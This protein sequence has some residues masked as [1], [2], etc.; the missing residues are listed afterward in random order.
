MSKS[1]PIQVT[2]RKG[3]DKYKHLIVEAGE[4]ACRGTGEHIL[5]APKIK[6][7]L[8]HLGG[9]FGYRDPWNEIE[10]TCMQKFLIK[11]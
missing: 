11:D 3:V 9:W 10:H 7:C 4:K 2:T 5:L 6:Y 1:N 8:D